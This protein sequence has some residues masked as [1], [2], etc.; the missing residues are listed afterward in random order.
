MVLSHLRLHNWCVNKNNGTRDVINDVLHIVLHIATL[1][2]VILSYLRLHDWCV[3][4][5]D[6]TGFVIPEL[7]IRK[8]S[9]GGCMLMKWTGFTLSN[10]KCN[11]YRPHLFA[12]NTMVIFV[13]NKK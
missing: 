7:W 4:K 10:I 9:N 2:I 12:K 1:I 5:N 3:N 13:F 6:G 11:Y 8:A